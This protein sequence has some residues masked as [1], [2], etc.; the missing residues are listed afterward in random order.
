MTN[1][2]TASWVSAGAAMVQAVGAVAAIW[3]TVHLARSSERR[4]AAAERSAEAVARAAEDAANRRKRSAPIEAH[5]SVVKEAT[6]HASEAIKIIL[7]EK[8]QWS[9]K[10]QN[11]RYSG[12]EISPEYGDIEQAYSRMLLHN[13]SDQKSKRAIS[14]MMRALNWKARKSKQSGNTVGAS[15]VADFF[16]K[17]AAELNDL[18]SRVESTSIQTDIYP[19]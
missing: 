15:E 9:K 12:F 8:E 16:K 7:S 4:V 18:S 6:S 17:W 14:D 10:P 5:N 11:I 19:T 3:A 2:E 13:L 1:A